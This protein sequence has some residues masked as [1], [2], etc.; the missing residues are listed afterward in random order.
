[1]S[2]DDYRRLIRTKIVVNKSHGMR[3][4]ILRVTRLV[5]DDEDVDVYLDARRGNATARLRLSGAAVPNATASLLIDLL[6]LTAA[7]GV[8]IILE[9]FPTT[10][11]VMILDQPEGEFEGNPMRWALD[12][13]TS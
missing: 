10:D 2:D 12:T 9:Y 7:G 6:K 5:L 8:R 3:E 11:E 4:S 13:S 1:M